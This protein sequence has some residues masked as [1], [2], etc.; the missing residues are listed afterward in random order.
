MA[1]PFKES[2]ADKYTRFAKHFYVTPKLHRRTVLVTG[3]SRGIGLA[4]A[5]AFG[6]HRAKHIFL[7]GRNEE[8][9]LEAAQ[10][11]SKGCRKEQSVHV[12]VGNVKDRDF[13][14]RLRHEKLLVSCTR[15]GIQFSSSEADVFVG[16]HRYSG[17]CSRT[18]ALVTIRG[19]R[20]RHTR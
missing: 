7:V 15:T 9:L 4:I 17:E 10:L 8:S 2:T 18:G 14:L 3:A 6:I 1:L 19:F 13:W 12:K 20:C 5:F 11:V 16:R